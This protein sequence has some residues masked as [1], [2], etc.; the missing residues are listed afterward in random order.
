MLLELRPL[1]SVGVRRKRVQMRWLRSR[2]LAVRWQ[3]RLFRFGNAVHEMGLAFGHRSH[4]RL[5]RW[6]PPNCHGH[7]DF[8]Q[9]QRNAHRQG[10][11]SNITCVYIELIIIKSFV[12]WVRMQSGI[13]SWSIYYYF[14]FFSLNACSQKVLSEMRVVCAIE[15][16]ANR[17][18]FI[19]RYHSWWSEME[20]ISDTWCCDRNGAEIFP[21]YYL[22][23][24]R[25][26]G[27]GGGI[28]I[29]T[30]CTHIY[31]GDGAA[32]IRTDL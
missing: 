24:D 4:L 20:A 7:F 25:K 11:Y 28:E 15:S 31:N 19:K 12:K 29:D 26:A 5:V 32:K 22:P 9:A 27:M 3:T 1:R 16:E 18:G 17:N 8:R 10:K 6:H 14:F 2:T 13:G 30:L 23:R 21:I